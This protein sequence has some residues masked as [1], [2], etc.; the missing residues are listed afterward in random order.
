MATAPPAEASLRTRKQFTYRGDTRIF[1]TRWYFDGGAPGT[2][3][4][5]DTLAAA[6][7]A[8]E[9]NCYGTDVEF[10]DAVGYDAGSDVPVHTTVYGVAGTY[11]H[12][13][14]IR[15]PGDCA[16]VVRITT[17][18]RSIKNHPI[19]QYKF[20][21]AIFRADGAT[22]DTWSTFQSAH[23]KSCID[24]WIAGLS[25]GAVEHHLTDR[26]G[27]AGLTTLIEPLITHRD[28]PR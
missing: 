10:V 3:A 27:L 21:R 18:A 12:G 4:H 14:E 2:G 6:A 7:L 13:S 16:G 5:W 11:D 17:D 23:W 24:N 1:G 9:Q 22:V 20:L 26:K 15:M 28:F 19:Y 25:D 8:H